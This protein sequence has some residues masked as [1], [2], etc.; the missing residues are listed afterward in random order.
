MAGL[1]LN[2]ILWTDSTEN[3]G[4]AAQLLSNTTEPLTESYTTFGY[5]QDASVEVFLR[6][7]SIHSTAGPLNSVADGIIIIINESSE[8]AADYIGQR[9]GVPLKV[10]VSGNDE[11]KAW[12][13][14]KGYSHYAAVDEDVARKI[15]KT[16]I[17][18]DELILNA[19][20]TLDK[21]GNSLISKEELIL[22]GKELDQ[23]VSSDLAE[24]II[25]TLSKDGKINFA[26]FKQWWYLGR[27]NFSQFRKMVELEM[28]IGKLVKKGSSYVGDYMYKIEEEVNAPDDIS[29]TTVSI[30]P[31]V[32]FEKGCSFG[33]EVAGAKE[34]AAIIA[35]LPEYLSSSFMSFSIEFQIDDAEKGSGVVQSLESVQE[36][37]YAMIPQAQEMQNLYGVN[38]KFRHSGTSVFIDIVLSGMFAEMIKGQIQ[39]SI[40]NQL[41]SKLKFIN[42]FFGSYSFTSGFRLDNLLEITIEELV[43]ELTQFKVESYFEN[44]NIQAVFNNALKNT[45]VNKQLMQMNM[46]VFVGQIIGKLLLVIRAF[47]FKSNYDSEELAAVVK[48]IVEF[49]YGQT[50]QGGVETDQWIG[51]QNT[52]SSFQQMA[53]AQLG[54]IKAMAGMFLAPYIETLKVLNFDK[55]GF[56]Y[57]F[58]MSSVHFKLSIGLAG[59]T[60]FLR[61]NILDG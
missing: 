32:D 16:A 51:L 8:A 26:Q 5:N 17:K 49:V 35:S 43:K 1:N 46:P 6:G 21:D 11:V 2:F 27:A 38:I 39:Q 53:Q 12:A 31:L 59:I 30:K 42:K 37:V 40:G 25:S 13:E 20:K 34:G 4:K 3:G 19:F 10:V 58:P 48:E 61:Q 22:V 28:K 36:M 18:N 55:I 56:A 52:L 15:V 50:Q 44:N 54:G 41:S 24:E 57:I 60:S 33:F 9:Q 7:S 47:D 45:V 23:P 29:R 14:S